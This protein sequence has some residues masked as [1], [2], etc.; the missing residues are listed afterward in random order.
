[1]NRAMLLPLAVYLGVTLLVPI[2]NGAATHVE[3]WIHAAEVV[4]VTAALLA[5]RV[6][7]ARIK[8]TATTPRDAKFAKDFL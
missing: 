2:L 8:R 6:G 1:M 5:M 3:F 4:I 7:I